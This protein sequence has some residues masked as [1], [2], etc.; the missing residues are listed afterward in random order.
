MSS[1][2]TIFGVLLFDWSGKQCAL[3]PNFGVKI[4]E[5]CSVVAK[6]LNISLYIEGELDPRMN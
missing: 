1:G 6:I 5:Y 2:H 3:L 4:S